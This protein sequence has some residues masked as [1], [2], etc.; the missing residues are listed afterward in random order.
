MWRC[1]KAPFA[2]AWLIIFTKFNYCASVVR[3]M[4]TDYEPNVMYPL[5]KHSVV[6]C[7]DT[8]SCDSAVL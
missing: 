2:R 5:N 7:W 4:M 3:L 8:Q 1:I 6:F